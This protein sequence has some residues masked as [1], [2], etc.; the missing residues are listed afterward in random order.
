MSSFLNWLFLFVY[1]LTYSFIYIPLQNK[2][3]YVRRKKYS[4]IK[5]INLYVDK[6]GIKHIYCYVVIVFD[7]DTGDWAF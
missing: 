4:K 6:T 3:I 1:R 5:S 7:S 2:N